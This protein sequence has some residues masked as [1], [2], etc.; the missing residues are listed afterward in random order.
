MTVPPIRYEILHGFA[1]ADRAAVARLFW[2]AFSGKLGRLLGPE[3]KALVFLARALRPAQ[4]LCAVDASGQVLGAA[5]FKTREGGLIAAGYAD[6][7]AV[8]GWFGAAWRGPL[9]D[10]T[11]RPLAEGQLLMDGLFVAAGARGLGLGGAL[12]DR[13]MAEARARG[14]R[15]V[16]LDVIETNPRARALYLRKGF[17]V[18]GEERLGVLRFLFGFRHSTTMICPVT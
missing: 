3:E 18:A 9:L 11:E 14:L 5:G 16:R 15:E 12:I 17:R 2:E 10:L 4:A 13:V 6:L 1:E 7:A 8:Y